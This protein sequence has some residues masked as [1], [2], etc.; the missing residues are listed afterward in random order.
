[1]PELVEVVF[2]LPLHRRFTYA[3]PEGMEIR[4][5]MR[6][7]APFRSR[8]LLGYVVAGNV[9]P[10]EGVA[11]IREVLR[12]IDA[13]PL[14]EERLLALAGWLSGMYLCSL[15]EALGAMLPGGRREVESEEMVGE[16]WEAWEALEDREIRLSAGQ[17]EAV[18][19][20]SAARSGLFYLHGVTGSGKTEVFLRAAAAT[21]AAGRGVI[22]LVPEIALTHQV[23]EVFS[24]RFGPTVA[25][26]HSGLTPSQRLAEWGRV[27][28]GEA[29]LVI[30]ARS[31]V[32]APLRDLGL[33]VI[34]EEH[35]GSYKSGTTPRYHARQ[36]AMHRAQSEGAVLVMGSAT[37]SLEAWQAIRAG[38]LACF[39]LGERLSGG[40]LPEVQIRSLAGESVPLSR[41]LIA[42]IRRTKEAGRQTILFLNRRGFAYFFHCRSC[43]FEMKCR[44]CS[45]ALTFHKKRG[46]MVCHYCG[47]QTPP[48]AVCPECGSVD[49]GYSGF[50]T[51]K[52]EEE[53]ARLFPDLAVRRID[54]DAVSRRGALRSLLAEF[55]SGRIDILVGTQ[56]VA[57]GLNFPGVKLVGI[58]LADSGLR[59]PDFRAAERTFALIVQVSGR[60]G[61]YHP[62]GKVVIQTF[63]P[64]NRTIT[65][66][67][68]GRL[69]EFYAE[70]LEARRALGFPP[71]TRLI[72]FV[73]RSRS[74]AKSAQ[75]AR[76]FAGLLGTA[77]EVEVLGPA[78]CPLAE[79]A[80][81]SRNQVLLRSPDFRKMHAAAKRGLASFEAQAGVYV[82][83]D[84]DPVSLL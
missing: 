37:P 66:A 78:E 45:V 84:V 69:E 11:E 73:F 35:E 68:E 13:R 50:G 22:Y 82:E 7:T 46:R 61:R 40:S 72:R 70:E 39:T 36:V 44:R 80:G 76:D 57:K 52:I 42:E 15:G 24:K 23:V 10:P 60:A 38:R 1:M 56:M 71:Y 27:L 9:S 14:F 74:A 32:F 21:L 34:D 17:Q 67:A 47:Y 64:S 2:N 48:V 43:G 30:G 4:T 5:G 29:R 53:L 75:A 54:T 65:L 31:A 18:D 26:L 62:D 41:A 28:A 33:L 81:N 59:L 55:R 49:V 51:E 83:V 25:V 79:I 3:V 6:V 19:R 20:L 77:P 63:L 16:A 12:R 58:V 8:R